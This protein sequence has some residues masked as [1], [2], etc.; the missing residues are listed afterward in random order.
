MERLREAKVEFEDLFKGISPP[1]RRRS[2]PTS[3]AL[4]RPFHSDNSDRR[5]NRG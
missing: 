5:W 4:I 1:L 2:L 3:G